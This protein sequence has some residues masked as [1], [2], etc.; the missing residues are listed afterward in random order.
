MS[1]RGHNN[2]QSLLPEGYRQ[3]EYI[4]STGTQYINTNVN[5]LPSVRLVTEVQYTDLSKSNSMGWASSSYR[6]V[7][8]FNCSSNGFYY[9]YGDDGNTATQ[10]TSSPDGDWHT[11]DISNGSQKFDS[12]EYGNRT[13]TRSGNTLYLFS[14]HAQWTTALTLPCYCKMKYCDI[15]RNGSIIRNFIPALRISNNKPGLYDTANK[16]FYIN[17]GTGQFLYGEL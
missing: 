2:I 9:L 15:Y 4:E 6:E 14:V 10:V 7:F 8:R 5:N 17:D 1:K 12:I 13:M 11:W 16:T 3:L